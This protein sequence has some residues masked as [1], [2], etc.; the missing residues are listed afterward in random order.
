[1]QH[2][3]EAISWS[4]SRNTYSLHEQT[5]IELAPIKIFRDIAKVTRVHIMGS[6]DR[7]SIKRCTLARCCMSTHSLYQQNHIY[8]IQKK[9]HMQSHSQLKQMEIL[10]ME[11]V[12]AQRV[13]ASFTSRSTKASLCRNTLSLYQWKHIKQTQEETQSIHKIT[14][15][16]SLHWRKQQ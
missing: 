6:T 13:F 4:F 8:C 1:M 9:A 2:Q 14:Y 11:R 16:Q 15:S 10:Q 3:Y 5:H 7:S 12:D